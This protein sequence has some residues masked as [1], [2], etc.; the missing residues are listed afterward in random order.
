MHYQGMH[1]SSVPSYTLMCDLAFSANQI[2]AKTS[3]D[4]PRQFFITKKTTTKEKNAAWLASM[5]LNRNDNSNITGQ[6]FLI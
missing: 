6:Y 4:Q 2:P 3:I 5:R 1:V